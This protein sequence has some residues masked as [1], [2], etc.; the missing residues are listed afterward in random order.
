M[1]DSQK[2]Y[3]L[4]VIYSNWAV[5]TITDFISAESET[6]YGPMKIDRNKGNETNRTLCVLTDKLFNAMMSKYG[7]RDQ[8]LDFVMSEYKLREHNFPRQGE[9]NNLFIPL[10]IQLSAT[11]CH[12]QIEQK[13]EALYQMDVTQA[14]NVKLHIPLK[15]RE[16]DKHNGL[17][18][19]TFSNSDLNDV[20]VVKLMLN[21]TWWTNEADLEWSTLTKCYWAKERKATSASSATSASNVS[22]ASNSSSA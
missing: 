11:E 13:L 16:H 20:A 3:K 6:G 1:T 19:L 4:A 10:P 5:P 2:S 18:F 9:V 21:D 17:A 15:S 14:T 22:N 7:R 8:N 12:Q